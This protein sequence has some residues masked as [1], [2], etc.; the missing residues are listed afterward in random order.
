MKI[1]AKNEETLLIGDLNRHIGRAVRDNHEKTSVAGK[2]LID[3]IGSSNYVI[4]NSLDCEKGGPFTHYSPSEPQN[5]EKKSL[6][7]YVIVSP[8]LV[9]YINKLE[10]DNSLNW[11]PCKSINGIL[12]FPD[13]YALHLE[14]KNIPMRNTDFLPGRKKTVWNTKKRNGWEQY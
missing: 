6:L 14:F 10:I 11:T 13:H 9:Q 4:V 5:N 3:W 1:E 8:G 2:L 12:K 7:D